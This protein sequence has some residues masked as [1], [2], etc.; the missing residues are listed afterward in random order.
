MGTAAFIRMNEQETT[1]SFEFSAEQQLY[2]APKKGDSSPSLVSLLIKFPAIVG[3]ASFVLGGAQVYG[4]AEEKL[5]NLLG[6]NADKIMTSAGLTSILVAQT[7]GMSLSGQARKQFQVGHPISTP[8]NLDEKDTIR[9][10]NAGRGFYN[11]VEQIGFLGINVYM[12]REVAGLPVVASSLMAAWG[13]GRVLY[14][15][16]YAVRGPP[17]RASGFIVSMLASSAA[18]GAVFAV[19]AKNVLAGSL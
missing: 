13:V 3:A 6:A 5:G 18:M 8:T 14:T 17:G 19:T 12:C 9:F 16:G 1:M 11:M 2:P 4:G 10:L 15:Y 7:F